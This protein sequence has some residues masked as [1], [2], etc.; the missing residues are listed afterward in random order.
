MISRLHAALSCFGVAPVRG[1]SDWGS[2][3]REMN[4]ESQ[5]IAGD[6][7]MKRLIVGWFGDGWRLLSFSARHMPSSFVDEAID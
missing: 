2:K 3:G 6:G 7:W 4:R 5:F 1:K